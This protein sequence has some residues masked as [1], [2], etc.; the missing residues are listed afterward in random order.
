MSTIKIL[1]KPSGS[2][3]GPLGR[4]VVSSPQGSG[5]VS[6]N[7]RSSMVETGR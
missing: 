3:D 6:H 5:E 4:A 2:F 7:H 1:A